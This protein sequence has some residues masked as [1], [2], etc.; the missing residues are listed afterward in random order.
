MTDYAKKFVENATVSFRVN[1]KQ[2][3]KNDNKIWEKIEKLL[4]KDFE[5]KPV[6]GDDD[7]YIKTKMKIYADSTIT[8]FHNKEIPKGKALCKCLSITMLVS[9]I[10]VNKNIIL[11]Y[12]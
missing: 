3:L 2:L 7:K 1:D 10:K 5:S 6:Y 12:F 8:D 11:K 4:K 9:V